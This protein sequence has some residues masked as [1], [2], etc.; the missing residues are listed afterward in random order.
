MRW[1]NRIQKTV[2]SIDISLATV[3]LLELSKS[4]TLY[5]VESFAVVPLHQ[6]PLIDKNIATVNIIADAI[7]TAL[8][9]YAMGFI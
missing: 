8:R 6:E 1:F 3:K 9:Q 4:G 5:K 2:L 7:K